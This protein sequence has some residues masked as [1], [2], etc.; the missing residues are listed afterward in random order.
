MSGIVLA[1]ERPKYGCIT[2]SWILKWIIQAFKNAYFPL[3]VGQCPKTKSRWLSMFRY[4]LCCTTIET[5]CNNSIELFYCGT[6]KYVRFE[7]HTYTLHFYLFLLQL[8]ILSK[9]ARGSSK[10][11]RNTMKSLVT[12]SSINYFFDS[13]IHIYQRW[14]VDTFTNFKPLEAVDKAVV[15]KPGKHNGQIFK[16]FGWAIFSIKIGR[17]HQSKCIGP[18]DA[19]PPFITMRYRRTTRK[20]FLAVK[21]WILIEVQCLF[22]SSIA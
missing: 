15:T 7:L 8:C 17:W 2:D 9:V 13:I 18:S 22:L 12:R 4:V 19:W 20:S 16:I 6:A 5:W 1:P 3:Q 11:P 21:L 14:M 10:C